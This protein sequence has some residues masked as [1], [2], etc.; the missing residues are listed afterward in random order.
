MQRIL[1]KILIELLRTNGHY[2]CELQGMVAE[3]LHADILGE[4]TQFVSTDF[5][6]LSHKYHTKFEKLVKEIDFMEEPKEG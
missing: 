3:N 5:K 2:Q 6:A 4:E 1:L